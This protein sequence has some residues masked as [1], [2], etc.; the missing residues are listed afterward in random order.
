MESNMPIRPTLKQLTVLALTLGLPC[1]PHL[2]LAAP[3]TTAPVAGYARSFLV[4]LKL[5]NANI[6]ILETGQKFQ[7]DQTGHFGPFQYSVG[8]PITLQF[9]KWGYQTTQSATIIVPPEGLAGTYDNITFQIP[10][11]ETYYLLA[12]VIGAKIDDNSCH[13]T[14]TITAYHK[15]LEDT[16]QGIADATVTLS[17]AVSV[18]PFY[19]DIYQSGPLKGKTNPFTRDLTK[20]SEDGG[21]AFF[22]LPPRDEPYVISAV[23]EGVKFSE[24]SFICKKGAFINLSPPRGPTVLQS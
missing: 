6:T 11:V 17:P 9:D 12:K 20:S 10:A 19:F 3:A 5:G 18:I 15:T 4:G 16:P 21:V 14:A 7:T 2:A 13:L 24:A 22:N 1:I 8:Q 23:K